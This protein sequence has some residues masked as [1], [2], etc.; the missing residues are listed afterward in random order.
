[1]N[2]YYCVPVYD[3]ALTHDN[4]NLRDHLWYVERDLY[5]SDCAFREYAYGDVFSTTDSDSF[6]EMLEEHNEEFKKMC[7]EKNI[8]L[9]LILVDD[10]IN[11]FELATKEEFEGRD[12]M[13]MS[14]YQ[15]SPEEVYD[16][17]VDSEEYTTKV[18]DF[19]KQYKRNKNIVSP[20]ET[21]EFR[22]SFKNPDEEDYY[23]SFVK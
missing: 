16:Q 15:I 5:T 10:G 21:S 9:N 20:I 1:M 3:C 8:P 19:F 18:K 22:H 17:Y 13:I 12:E 11:L 7:E 14:G 2:K 23:E 6:N 4:L